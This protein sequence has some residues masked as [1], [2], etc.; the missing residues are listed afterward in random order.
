MNLNFSKYLRL[1]V[2][3]TLELPSPGLAALVLPYR[4]LP[5][6]S[7]SHTGDRAQAPQG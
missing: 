4:N 2:N 3:G 5:G 7:Y 1:E 6:T